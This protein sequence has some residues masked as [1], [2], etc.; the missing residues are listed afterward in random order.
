MTDGKIMATENSAENMKDN[1]ANHS[2]SRSL[3]IT[4]NDSFVIIQLLEK[5]FILYFDFGALKLAIFGSISFLSSNKLR[6]AVPDTPEKF[7]KIPWH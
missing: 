1:T 2:N 4:L 5:A 6:I 7:R 3:L